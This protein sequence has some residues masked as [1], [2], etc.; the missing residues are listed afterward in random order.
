VAEQEKK[1]GG[2]KNKLKI[3]R[4]VSS[5]EGGVIRDGDH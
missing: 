3:R 1:S 5:T 2:H 4:G